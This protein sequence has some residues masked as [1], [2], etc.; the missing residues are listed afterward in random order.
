MPPLCQFLCIFW[1]KKYISEGEKKV[2]RL[3]QKQSA[4]K[5]SKAIQKQSAQKAIKAPQTGMDMANVSKS[6]V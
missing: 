3:I 5:A 4:Q 2:A 6:K 1:R